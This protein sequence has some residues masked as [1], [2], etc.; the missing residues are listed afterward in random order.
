MN[1]AVNDTSFK[2]GLS[3]DKNGLYHVLG[4]FQIFILIALCSKAKQLRIV[5][6]TLFS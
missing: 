4:H 2:A 1:L 6:R 5:L 3:E